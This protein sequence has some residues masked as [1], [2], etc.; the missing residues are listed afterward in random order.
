MASRYNWANSDGLTVPSGRRTSDNEGG[1]K[2]PGMGA[3]QEVK[4]VIPEGSTGDATV[5]ALYP[6]TIPSGA[7][8][9]DVLVHGNGALTSLVDLIV[10]IADADGGSTLTDPNGLVLAIDAAE[11]VA[12]RPTGTVVGTAFDGAFMET[13]VVPLSEAV[14]V[15]ASAT[16]ASSAGD[17]VI[18][19]QYI[20]GPTIP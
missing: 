3:I 6:A 19:V 11:V 14:Y 13:A 7:V 16:T 1:A 9:T 10:G 8:I 17:I 15:T 2:V 20:D 18:V 12:L 4:L 5:Q